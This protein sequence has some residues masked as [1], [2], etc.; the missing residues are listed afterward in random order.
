[1]DLLLNKDNHK[2]FSRAVMYLMGNFVLSEEGI[3]AVLRTGRLPDLLNFICKQVD[4]FFK[5]PLFFKKS[6]RIH[7]NSFSARS[8][9]KK[10]F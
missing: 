1:M 8:S 9:Q 5:D 10:D 7:P 3:Q 4:R 2:Y 6:S